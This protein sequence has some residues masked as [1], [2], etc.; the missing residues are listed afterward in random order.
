MVA[1]CPTPTQWTD[2]RFV[3]VFAEVVGVI[4]LRVLLA[5]KVTT[6]LLVLVWPGADWRLLRGGRRVG[7]GA[8]RP[9]A[10]GA[11]VIIHYIG[12]GL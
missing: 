12:C 9:G 4:E 8:E 11:V 2:A 5:V 3:A 7:A 6:Y 1:E 10:V